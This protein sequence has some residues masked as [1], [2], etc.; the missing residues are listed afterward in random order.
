MEI[1]LEEFDPVGI[2]RFDTKSVNELVLV[3]LLIIGL[4]WILDFVQKALIKGYISTQ[5]AVIRKANPIPDHVRR[6]R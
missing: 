2:S 5:K 6:F 3:K 4:F 1:V